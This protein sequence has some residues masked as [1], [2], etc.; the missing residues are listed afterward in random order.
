V[1][2]GNSSADTV[3][4]S[5]ANSTNTGVITVSA[6]SSSGVFA[7]FSNRGLNYADDGGSENGV[8]VIAPGVGITSTYM[9]GGYATLDGTS[10]ASPHVAGVAALCKVQNPTFTPAD[11]KQAVM[12]SP[13]DGSWDLG[14]AGI[15]GLGTWR[16]TSGDPDGFYEPLVNGAAFAN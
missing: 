7:S 14:P 2:A 3:N 10:M 13:P 9:G 12:T 16:A 8:D 15:F 5:P 1:A 11:V 4:T 6:L